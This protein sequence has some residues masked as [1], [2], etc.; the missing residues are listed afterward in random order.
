MRCLAGLRHHGQHILDAYMLRDEPDAGQ[1]RRDIDLRVHDSGETEERVANAVPAVGAVH[2]G[3]REI[4]VRGGAQELRVGARP[5]GVDAGI[6]G[7]LHAH[8][9][10]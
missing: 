5:G 10:W 6:G 9:A 8:A 7:V 3:Y 2:A 1:A 4:D